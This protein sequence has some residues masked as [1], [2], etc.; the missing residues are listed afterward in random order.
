VLRDHS[1]EKLLNAVAY[2][3]QNTKACGK[4]K[5][6]KLL[7]FLDFQHYTETGRSVTGLEYYAWPMGPVPRT[8][9]EELALPAQDFAASFEVENL[10]LWNG[11]E[12]LKLR[13]L[14][15]FDSSHFS[16]RELRIYESL[17]RE[18]RTS[19]ADLMVEATHLENLPWDQVYRKEG[20]P[21]ELIPYELAL[22]KGDKELVEGA[23]KE[24]EEFSENYS[25]RRD[26]P[27]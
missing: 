23:I 18:F 20:R 13:P 9:H 17:A 25:D 21:Q 27:S 24:H 1:R 7:Y 5:L 22:R 15:P 16:K 3:V 4:T 26:V 11:N 2:F 14:K 19:T 10:S 6:Y 12:M 8:L